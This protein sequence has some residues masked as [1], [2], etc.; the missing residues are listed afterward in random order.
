MQKWIS[1]AIFSAVLIKASLYFA[2][3][4]STS[5]SFSVPFYS[6]CCPLLIK[7]LSLLSPVKPPVLLSRYNQYFRLRKH[8]FQS[9]VSPSAL[10]AVAKV[11]TMQFCL[12]DSIAVSFFDQ[13]DTFT[14][15]RCAPKKGKTPPPPITAE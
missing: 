4:V 10:D 8:S 15:L 11:H 9:G 1:I 12:L 13:S 7:N 14:T 2:T 6:C 5:S 3:I